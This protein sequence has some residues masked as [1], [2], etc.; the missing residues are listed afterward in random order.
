[1]NLIVK[2][3]LIFAM[4]VCPLNCLTGGFQAT[5]DTVVDA[6]KCSCCAHQTQH[7]TPERDSQCPPAEGSPNCVCHGALLAA[8]HSELEISSP[9]DLCHFDFVLEIDLQDALAI[10][11]SYTDRVTSV[12]AVLP[13]GQRARVLFQSFLL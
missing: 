7:A 8:G 2:S 3:I 13:V 6:P 4:V 10:G 5:A 12:D 9:F 11:D 1:M